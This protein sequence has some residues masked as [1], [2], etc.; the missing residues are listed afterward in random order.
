MGMSE[1]KL[2]MIKASACIGSARRNVVQTVELLH[3]HKNCRIMNTLVI[4]DMH[5]LRQKSQK[6]LPENQI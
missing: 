3:R 4:G 5:S 1:A 6:F 2:N